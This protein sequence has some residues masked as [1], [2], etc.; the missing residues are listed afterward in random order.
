MEKINDFLSIPG[1]GY[2]YGD[3]SGSGDGSG[4]GSGYGYGDGDG[5]GDGDGYGYGYGYGDGVE[6]IDGKK[7]YNVDGLQT[8]LLSIKGMLMGSCRSIK[9][10]TGPGTEK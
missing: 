1:S 2:G 7:I 4:Y 8:A 5:S 10:L 3:G 9:F 6:E